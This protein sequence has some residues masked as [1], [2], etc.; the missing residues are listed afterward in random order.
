MCA[1]M[2]IIPGHTR[3]ANVF[4]FFQSAIRSMFGLCYYATQRIIFEAKSLS[5]DQ[6]KQIVQ[7]KAVMRKAFLFCF[8]T[9]GDRPDIAS[10][11]LLTLVELRISYKYG[12][13]WDDVDIE[14]NHP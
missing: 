3:V 10:E 14:T 6:W 7:F 1:H 2:V 11:S 9:Q 8:E 5:L 4:L 12:N 13:Q